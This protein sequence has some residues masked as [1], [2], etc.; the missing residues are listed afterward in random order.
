MN[1]KF[2]IILPVHNGGEYVKACVES[3]LAQTLDEFELV[4]LDNCST[5]GTLEWILSLNDN[6]IKIFPSEKSLSI[7]DNWARITAVPKNEFITLIG[8][9]DILYPDY[10]FIMNALIEKY[11][12]ANLFQSHFAFI[13]A[14]GKVIKKC[15]LMAEI[16]SVYEFLASSLSNKI[17]IIGTGFMMRA[18]DYNDIKGIPL[19]PNLLF[20]DFELWTNIIA[21]SY[22]VVSLKECFAFRRHSSTT[23]TSPDTKMQQAFF[24]FINYLKVLKKKDDEFARVINAYGVHFISIN[25]KGLAH[26]LMRTPYNKR[27]GETVAIFLNRC[28]KLAD[29]LIP[30]NNF[31]PENK[32]NLRLAKKIDSNKLTR[33]L[34]LLFKKI[35]S[36]PIYS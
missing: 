11:P 6:R 23:G 25:C 2:S 17:D 35:Y 31:N 10:L 5:D 20:A 36:K 16:Q 29:E 28:K 3:I 13:D 15:K 14:N 4:V 18:K 30:G 26:R 32:F 1:K 9:D 7:E 21:K 22:L 34:F 12:Q 8:H 33:T 19:Y 27:N 24:R